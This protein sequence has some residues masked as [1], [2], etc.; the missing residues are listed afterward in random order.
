MK[1]RCTQVRRPPPDERHPATGRV[2]RAHLHFPDIRVGKVYEV[3]KA[4]QMLETKPGFIIVNDAGDRVWYPSD[5][6]EVVGDAESVTD[7]F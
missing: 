3:V 4:E 2:E 1:V 7:L 5:F 6:F